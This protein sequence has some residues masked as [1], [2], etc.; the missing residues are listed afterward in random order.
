MAMWFVFYRFTVMIAREFY[1]VLYSMVFIIILGVH[2]LYG[3]QLFLKHLL[4]V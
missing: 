4:N 2:L 1:L 3:I